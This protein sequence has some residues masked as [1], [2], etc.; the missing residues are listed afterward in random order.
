MAKHE[1]SMRCPACGGP[2]V[3]ETRMDTVHYESRRAQVLVRGHWCQTCGEAVFDG[4]E[5]QKREAA[6]LALRA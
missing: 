4:E 5:L 3:L 2:M 1:T 6:F